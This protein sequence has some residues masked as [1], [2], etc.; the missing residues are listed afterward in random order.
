MSQALLGKIE[1]RLRQGVSLGEAPSHVAQCILDL[2][3]AEPRSTGFFDIHRREIKDGD[4]VVACGENFNMAEYGNSALRYR[5]SH[6]RVHFANGRWMGNCED[7]DQWLSLLQRGSCLIDN[8]PNIL[9]R[10]ANYC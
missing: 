9:A 7:Y 4:V 3:N 2:V 1:L 6:V 8:Q 5:Y 10:A